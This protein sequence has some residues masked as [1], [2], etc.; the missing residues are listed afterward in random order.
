MKHTSVWM[1]S[2]LLLLS[3]FTSCECP[4]HPPT[5]PVMS[6]KEIRHTGIAVILASETTRKCRWTP[7]HWNRNV[8]LTYINQYSKF[9]P[10]TSFEPLLF[11]CKV[12]EYHVKKAVEGRASVIKVAVPQMPIGGLDIYFDIIET[13]IIDHNLIVSRYIISSQGQMWVKYV[14]FWR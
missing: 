4:P 5:H 6:A 8:L 13:V 3:L 7:L 1:W 12:S 9:H 14:N 2:V 11:F 10:H